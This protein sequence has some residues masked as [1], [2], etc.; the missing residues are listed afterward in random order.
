MGL[1]RRAILV[2]DKDYGSVKNIH[3]H[4]QD[5]QSFILNMMLSFRICKNLIAKNLSYL[6]DA[7]SNK[8]KLGQNVLN[9]KIDWS[10]PGNFNS[11]SARCKRE[12][13]RMFIHIYLDHEIRNDAEDKF[14][15]RVA[16][17]LDKQKSDTEPLTQKEKDFLSAYVTEDSNGRKIINNTQIFEY[18]LCKGIRVLLSDFV[19][20]PVEASRAYT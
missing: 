7:C 6:L 8:S 3:K 18:M 2:A 16:E 9:E 4:Y 10:Y 1:N 17:L 19:S 20:D 11:D 12:K 5:N 15:A 14:R 13:G